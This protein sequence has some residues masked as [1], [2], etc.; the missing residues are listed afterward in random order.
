M[1]EDILFVKILPALAT[2]SEMV[3]GRSV[4]IGFFV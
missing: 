1:K 2:K 4:P 3:L